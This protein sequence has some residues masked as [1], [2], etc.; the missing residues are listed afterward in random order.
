VIVQSV[1][2][3]VSLVTLS[4]CASSTTEQ[5]GE[6]DRALLWAARSAEYQAISMQVYSQATRD[7][8]EFIAD[9]SW[10]AVPG[11]APD[12]KM[13]TAV[14][15]D[16]DETIVSGVDMALASVPYSPR[17]QYEWTISH[18]SVPVRGVAE[19]IQAAE[20][21]GIQP[22]FVTNRACE[23]VEG[24]DGPCPQEQA[25]VQLITELGIETDAAHV[26]LAHEKPEWGKEKVVRREFV[27]STHRVIMLFGDDYGDFVAC[28]RAVPVAP[29]TTG[30]T[31]A[32]RAE[33]LNTYSNFWGNGW[34]ILPNPMHGSWTSV[35]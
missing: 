33:A 4:A 25:V 28:T 32:S 6:S 11:V 14:I 20:N 13:P 2:L 8:P 29:C 3:V 16:V 27:A 22:F 34:Y 21:Q 35:R 24:V 1:I 19:F 5:S 9:T 15:L 30:A 7:L 23:E 26:L 10:S 12:P 18:A 31:R 17:N